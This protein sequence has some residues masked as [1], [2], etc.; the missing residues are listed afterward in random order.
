MEDPTVI[1]IKSDFS[2]KNLITMAKNIKKIIFYDLYRKEISKSAIK[3]EF[4]FITLNERDFNHEKAGFFKKK[5]HFSYWTPATTGGS[6]ISPAARENKL[7]G[8]T[9]SRKNIS[10]GASGS[11]HVL[12]HR[13]ACADAPCARRAQASVGDPQSR[14]RGVHL[15]TFFWIF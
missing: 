7:V 4:S 11:I 6:I 14:S 8:L 10:R 2:I 3:R 1:N 15:C 5:F 13:C 9:P 12:V